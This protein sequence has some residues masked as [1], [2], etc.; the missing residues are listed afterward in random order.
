MNISEATASDDLQQC[1][2]VSLAIKSS[3]LQFTGTKELYM[4]ST[5]DIQNMKLKLVFGEKGY[6]K[7]RLHHRTKFHCRDFDGCKVII[8]QN[9]LL[10][11]GVLN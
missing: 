1:N 3:F 2:H 5:L 6:Y 10:L 4:S 11:K 8:L 7:P 9:W